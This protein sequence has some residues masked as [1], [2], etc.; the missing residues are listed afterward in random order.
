MPTPTKKSPEEP[1]SLEQLQVLQVPE[2]KEIVWLAHGFSTRHAGN[3]TAYGGRSLNLGFTRED[4]RDSVEK[5]RRALLLA[6]G[7]ADN[8]IPWPL[9]TVKQIHSDLVQV[10]RS[11]TSDQFTGDGM[12]TSLPGIALAIQTADCFPILLVDRKNRAIGAFHA[13]WRGTV[14]RIVEKGLGIMRRE[15]GSLPEDIQAA[16]GAG[17]QRCC[18][19]VGEEVRSQFE[20]Q[21]SYGS[22]LFHEV[23][24]SNPVKEKYPLLF[25]N[26]RAPGH[27]DMGPKFHLDL[28]EAN[29]RQLVQS[30]VPASQ[31]T[32]LDDCTSC[33]VDKFFSHRAE[34]GVTGRMMAV[35]GMRAGR[36]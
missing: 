2:L 36:R 34:K 19:E 3:S 10:V 27:G 13:G 28:R 16:V 11:R 6:I 8:E 25:M 31:I 1:A 24:S 29:R 7:A 14:K 22:E 21:F 18:Y 5:N 23:F 32:A 15:Y 17:I 30:G 4:T 35:I 9:I 12:V 33:N 26:A 20:S